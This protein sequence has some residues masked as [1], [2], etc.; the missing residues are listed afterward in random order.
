MSYVLVHD[1]W[2]CLH[3]LREAASYLVASDPTFDKRHSERDQNRSKALNARNSQHPG[4]RWV[5]QAQCYSTNSTCAATATQLVTCLGAS[6][7]VHTY[8]DLVLLLLLLTKQ[9]HQQLVVQQLHTVVQLGSSR[10][11]SPT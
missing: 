8:C 5:E 2:P 6:A 11:H 3:V 4:H 7:E 1:R 10:W 9:M